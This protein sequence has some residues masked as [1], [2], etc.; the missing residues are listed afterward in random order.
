MLQLFT[1]IHNATTNYL[2]PENF[3]GNILALIGHIAGLG[4][5]II[6]CILLFKLFFG[7]TM[8]LLRGPGHPIARKVIAGAICVPILTFWIHRV[9]VGEADGKQWAVFILAWLLIQY[10]PINFLQMYFNTIAANSNITIDKRLQRASKKGLRSMKK[11]ERDLKKKERAEK[12]QARKGHVNPE[13][14]IIKV[15]SDKKPKT[16]LTYTITPFYPNKY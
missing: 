7:R 6:I 5:T 4:L 1:T 8:K 13:E 12:R 9:A 11:M 16:P 2:A 3:A 14:N 10:I 15:E